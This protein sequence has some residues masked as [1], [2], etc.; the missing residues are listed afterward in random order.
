MLIYNCLE[1][2]ERLDPSLYNLSLEY[3]VKYIPFNATLE[4]SETSAKEILCL[5][6]LI[7]FLLF[8]RFRFCSLTI[9]LERKSSFD[10]PGVSITVTGFVQLIPSSL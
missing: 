5:N 7:D 3:V 6:I 10:G 8:Y 9:D 1:K 2:R 4:T